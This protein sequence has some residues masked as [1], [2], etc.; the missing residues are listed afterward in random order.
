[1]QGLPDAA[2]AERVEQ[3][4]GTDDGEVKR[5][6]LG[7]ENA[8]ERIS[9]VAGETSGTKSRGNVDGQ[10]GISGVVYGIQES[11]LESYGTIEF[12]E[13]HLGRDLPGRGS[14]DEDII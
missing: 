3:G 2:D 1:M 11:S 4:I 8:I 9:V 12:A 6:S 14:G 5:E 7:R 10:Q 13:T